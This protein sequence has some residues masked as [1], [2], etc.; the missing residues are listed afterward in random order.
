[1]TKCPLPPE[2]TAQLT[3]Y[4]LGAIDPAAPLLFRYKKGECLSI[5]GQMPEVIQFIISGTVKVSVYASNGRSMMFCFNGPG[6]I[7][8]SI[9][10]LSASAFTATAI[11]VGEVLCIA[12]PIAPCWDFFNSDVDFLR[13]L[14]SDLSYSFAHSSRNAATN[15][16]YPLETRLCS[17]IGVTAQAGVFNERLTETAELLG[18]SYRHLL[19]CLD[20]LCGRGILSKQPKGYR[21]TDAAELDRLASDYYVSGAIR[22]IQNSE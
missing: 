10:L 16:L 17:Y 8:G 6:N 14:C 1:M 15:I 9:E 19:R 7:I 21:V 13:Y 12:V 4:G 22:R 11:A 3:Q 18:T 5:E 2:M 20:G